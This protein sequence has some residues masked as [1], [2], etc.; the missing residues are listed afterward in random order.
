MADPS[1]VI[2]V[3]LDAVHILQQCL[4]DW[5]EWFVPRFSWLGISISRHR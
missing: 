3:L 5:S 1:V 2:S 4:V